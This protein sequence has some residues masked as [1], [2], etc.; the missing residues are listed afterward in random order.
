MFCGVG[1]EGNS[2]PFLLTLPG[3]TNL[4][5]SRCIVKHVS[6]CCVNVHVSC[7]CECVCTCGTGVCQ[8]SRKS[9]C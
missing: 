7:E 1:V 4:P 9:P 6:G 2:F 3:F 5:D 8:N